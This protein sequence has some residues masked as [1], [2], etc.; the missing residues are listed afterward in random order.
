M[1]DPFIVLAVVL[2][3]LVAAVAQT[4][5]GSGYG[6]V[7]AP[8][9]VIV[10]PLTVPGPLLVSTIVVMAFV[11][12]THRHALALADLRPALVWA[13]PGVVVG[14]LVAGLSSPAVTMIAVGVIVLVGVAAAISGVQVPSS[15][16]ALRVAGALAGVFTVIAA[17]PGPPL[18]VVYRPEDSDRLRANLSAFFL[19]SS[20]G[21]LIPL[22]LLTEGGVAAHRPHARPVSGCGGRGA[23]R[24]T[25][26]P[27]SG[28]AH[29]SRR[30]PRP[31]RARRGI[32]PGTGRRSAARLTVDF[33][34]GGGRSRPDCGSRGW[35][36]GWR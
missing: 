10:E 6:I 18:T 11:V 35:S 7:A 14:F 29:N 32:A 31:V 19:I 8:L 16:G 25:V 4:A 22:V 15:V 26:S 21:T 13:V 23:R 2:I 12:A 33:S 30:L 27:G 3:S 5:T 36:L 17:T 24:A 9:L 28:G 1:S 34:G 20:V